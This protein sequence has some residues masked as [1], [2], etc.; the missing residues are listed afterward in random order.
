MRNKIHTFLHFAKLIKHS[1]TT[2]LENLIFVKTFYTRI[3][4]V[5]RTEFGRTV[6]F[7]MQ[8]GSHK[9]LLLIVFLAILEPV[10]HNTVFGIVFQTS[11]FDTVLY[12][13]I[14]E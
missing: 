14:G 5:L 1:S 9:L 12:H 8:F 3:S 7:H 6:Y 4:I 10:Q 13:I 2:N 11:Y